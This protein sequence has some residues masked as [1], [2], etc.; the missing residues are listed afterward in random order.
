MKSCF[1]ELQRDRKDL[2]SPAG[3]LQTQHA[4]LVPFPMF[5]TAQYC[6]VHSFCEQFLDK[7]QFL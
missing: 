5:C 3:S 1:L 4:G 7:N 6:R 2:A